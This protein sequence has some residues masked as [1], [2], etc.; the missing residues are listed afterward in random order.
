[1]FLEEV[2]VLI[3]EARFRFG[4]AQGSDPL[5]LDEPAVT[6][7]VGPNNSGKSMVLR[8]IAELCSNG[9]THRAILDGI[10]FRKHSTEEIDALLQAWTDHRRSPGEVDHIDHVYL[11]FG[12]WRMQV[13]APTFRNI[14]LNPDENINEFARKYAA[15]HML[16]LDGANRI[17]LIAERSRGDLKDPQN[18]FARILTNDT[19]RQLLR[20]VLFDAFGLYLGM[21]ISE[22][23]S[24]QLRYGS[25]PPP[26]ERS[27]EDATLEWMRNARPT[28]QWSDGMK[29]FTGML[30]ELRAGDPKIMIIDEPEAFL[31]PTL[32]YKLGREIA[33]TASQGD[34][35]IFVSTHSSQFLMGA[36]QSGVK[37]NVVRLTY[38]QGSA[39]AR[40]LSND[41]IRVM[42]Q[43]P[44]LRS[45]NALSGVFYEGVVVTEADADR[46]FYQ[47]INERL[48]AEESGRGAPN[49]LFLNANGKDSVNKIVGPLRVLGI[50]VAVILDIDALNTETNFPVLLEAT[51]YPKPHESIKIERA[52]VWSD[53]ISDNKNPKSAGG[54]SLL[55]GTAKEKAENLFD[56]LDQ[57]GLFVLRHGE[58]EHWLPGLAVPRSKRW[59][60]NIFESL[61]S[62]PK[63]P[64]YV[65]PD[66][67]DVWAYVDKVAAWIKDKARRGIPL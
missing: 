8:E 26:N 22:G 32:A 64:N 56:R 19:R 24:I 65:H 49:T 9:N 63:A 40:M 13:H 57:Y 50:P 18:T 47:E 51:N 62:D 45:A 21:D 35:Q 30:L 48:L 59:L 43:E 34:K 60:R 11:K 3:E 31:H 10:K 58:V 7:F 55:S 2:L 46:A 53:L 12:A 44:L 36:I 29:A 42:M 37:I 54:I 41:Y 28:D 1:M 33:H 61:G 38:Q 5:V 14:L 66:D 52:G 6:I 16:I 17:G 20:D 25:T 67:D 15:R 39:T 4:A 27:V 23:A